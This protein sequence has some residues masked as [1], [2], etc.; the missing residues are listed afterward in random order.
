MKQI[1]VDFIR[2]VNEFSTGTNCIY[3][4]GSKVCRSWLIEFSLKIDTSTKL[5]N[6]MNF[7]QAMTQGNDFQ[8]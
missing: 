2:P 4:S 3:Q 8:S 1:E 5:L 7:D 6:G